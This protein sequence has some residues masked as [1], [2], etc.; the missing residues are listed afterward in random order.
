MSG[1]K[2]DRPYGSFPRYGVVPAEEPTP[3][4][5]PLGRRQRFGVW[6]RATTRRERIELLITA[7]LVVAAIPISISALP[8]DVQLGTVD[9]AAPTPTL[10]IPELYQ[11][12]AATVVTVHVDLADGKTALGSGV[13]FDEDADILT[14]LH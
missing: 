4:A 9:T 7:V 3:E 13:V 10:S 5:P 8:K 14:A 2:A 6:L 11:K 1:S 12:L